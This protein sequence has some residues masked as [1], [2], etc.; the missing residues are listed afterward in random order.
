MK[1]EQAALEANRAFYRI[2][3]D[4]DAK[5]MDGLWAERLPVVCIHPGWEAL[6]DRDSVMHS[7]FGILADPP[8]VECRDAQVHM[9]GE[10]AMVI[11]EERIGDQSL[12]TT[13]L[14]VREDDAWKITHHQAGLL[15]DLSPDSFDEDEEDDE[16]VTPDRPRRLH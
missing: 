8:P 5:A 9:L 10:V 3:S 11:C 4:G 6:T 15:A 13:N 2:F 1:N 14:F 16:E 7:W 12:V